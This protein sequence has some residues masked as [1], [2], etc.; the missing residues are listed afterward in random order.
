ML[1]A[2]PVY[3][4]AKYAERVLERIRAHA[5][6]VLAID[7]G[8]SDG[9]GDLLDE[10]AP[11]L[12]V[13]VLRHPT[14]RG[15][16]RSLRDAFAWARERGFDWTVTIDC[17]EQHEPRAIPRFIDALDSGDFDVISGS[18]YLDPDAM[19][20]APPPERRKVNATIT[21]ELNN[22]V[23]DLIG[24]AITDAFCG[25]KAVR[26]DAAAAMDLDEDGYAMPMQFWVRAAAARL[27]VGE[28]PVKLIYNDP[29]RTFGGDLDDSTRRLAHYREV[30]HRELCRCADQLPEPATAELV[31]ECG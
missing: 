13:H 9:T 5:P 7:D 6:H 8:S 12:G 26:T 17:D 3:N 28:I 21:A 25:F 27:R 19:I 18:R 16:G 30:L 31:I 29:T 22:R 14:N 11:K 24:G 23:A 15:Y 1:V 20:D 2:V 10:L 4:E